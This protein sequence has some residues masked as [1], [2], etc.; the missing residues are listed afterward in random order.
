VTNFA[1]AGMDAPLVQDAR[2]Y[3]VTLDYRQSDP[4][5]T[6]HAVAAFAARPTETFCVEVLE[7]DSDG[8]YGRVV[9]WPGGVGAPDRTEVLVPRYSVWEFHLDH[10]LGADPPHDE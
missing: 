8:V 6:L 5:T 10:P 1:P 9:E 7:A 4:E 2:L 3:D